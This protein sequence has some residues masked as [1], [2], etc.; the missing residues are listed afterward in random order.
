MTTVIQESF[1]DFDS[2]RGLVL[3]SKGFKNKDTDVMSQEENM[4]DLL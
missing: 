4:V 1:I 2:Q 3:K